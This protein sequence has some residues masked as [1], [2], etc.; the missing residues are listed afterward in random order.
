MFG[1]K[2]R[3]RTKKKRTIVQK[4][5]RF[6]M[7]TVLSLVLLVVA[8]AII[9]PAFFTD[10]IVNA[11]RE[12]VNTTIDAELYLDGDDVDLTLWS[13]FP[14]VTLEMNNFGV[15]G[16]GE[17]EGDTLVA[18]DKF[19]VEIDIWSL[20][21]DK[22]K[23]NGIYL[24]RPLIQ[25][26]VTK[27]GK[28]NWDIAL[29]DTT[30]VEEGEE[31]TEAG[32]PFEFKIDEW[33]ITK[34]R[35][36]YDDRQGDTYVEI[37]G[38]THSGTGDFE[39]DLTDLETHTIFE[40]FIVA[41]GGVTY[42]PRNYFNMNLI[43]AMSEG[44]TKFE[45]KDNRVQLNEFVTEFSG[46]IKMDTTTGNTEFTKFKIEA[47][48][49]AFKNI[50]SLVPGM[51]TE[52]F[53]ALKTSGTL[54][55]K[56][57]LDGTLEASGERIP[58][59]GFMLN[60]GDG[61]FQYPDL[62]SKVSKINVD[63]NVE[64]KDGILDNTVVNLKKFSMLMGSNPISATA[65]IEGLSNMNI[66]AT[67]NATLNLAELTSIYPIE[68]VKMKGIFTLNG[69]A[70]GQY[71]DQ[72]AIP[73]VTAKM[74]MDKGYV[75]ADGFDKAL[76]DLTFDSKFSLASMDMTSGKFDLNKFNMVM[77]ED[78]FSAEFH[79]DDLEAI[80]FN[81]N[82]QGIVDLDKIMAMFPIE[83]MEL[84]GKFIIE[85]ISTEGNL[86]AIE[87]ERYGDIPTSGSVAIDKFKYFDE[88]LVPG[89]ITIET[90][91]M[92]FT[93]KDIKL[94]DTRGMMSKSD[95]ST[96]GSI[97]NYMGYLFS[98]SD[99]VLKGNLTLVSKFFDL[100][101]WMYMYMGGEAPT[102]AQQEAALAEVTP[103]S[104][105]EPLEVYPLP[106]NI[107][108]RF[109]TVVNEV[110]YSTAP[111]TDVAG[112]VI[113]KDGAVYLNGMRFNMY[114][115]RFI[116]NGYYSTQ[117]P[118][119][120]EYSFDMKIDKM[121]FQDAYKAFA[122]AKKYLPQTKD[123]EGAFSSDFKIS[124]SLAKDY[125]PNFDD[126]NM[127]GL[128]NIH[129]AKAKDSKLMKA[130]QKAGV[131]GAEDDITIENTLVKANIK[132]GYVHFQPFDFK[133]GNIP[134]KVQGK[135]GLA[136]DIDYKMGTDVPAGALGS[137]LNSQLTKWGVPQTN[138]AD[139]IHLDFGVTGTHKNPKVKLL[140][141]GGKDIKDQV[142]DKI[143]DE[144]KDKIDQQIDNA[145]DKVKPKADKIRSDA[146]KEAADIRKKAKIE[147]DGVRATGQQTAKSLRD[148]GA[149]AAQKIRDEAESQAQQTE[150]S[151]KNPLEKKAKKIAADKI[152]Q[153]G[154]KKAKA[155]EEEFE[156]K[157]V[158]AEEKANNTAQGI[159]D[160]AEDA[161]SK[162]ESTADKQIQ[163]LMKE[164][165]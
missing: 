56:T 139:K 2:R 142:K 81:G 73:A 133:A 24:D 104:E 7:F 127:D 94:K 15:V 22:F 121:Q 149:K 164:C 108:F 122:V 23:I 115:G 35:L 143:K 160:K 4:I 89:P 119:K 78:E 34:G 148:E 27:D 43:V 20:F 100:D 28:A 19:K 12:E 76:E 32:S 150:N 147:A 105:E 165:N 112:T 29:P 95:F 8:A 36:L 117:N 67:T 5:L 50:L 58:A 9:I 66:D 153:E 38:L 65:L 59:L 6:L 13:N 97:D 82:F 87:E 75:K 62:P 123:I 130:V 42:F 154:E 11:V 159:E 103:T 60:V 47:K 111:L 79:V 107:N 152:R 118:A 44:Y 85:D 101:E 40:E 51:Y 88:T 96:Q 162:I 109:S 46:G 80:N 25:G 69:T 14:N 125:M 84:G 17:F 131:K 77:D 135:S 31:P 163:D 63:L 156:K 55:F 146:D 126:L 102:E 64:N 137:A 83:G 113:M 52:S 10:D 45:F 161:A 116:S 99:T 151:A 16:K 157:A 144:V 54:A 3:N 114:G 158:A 48:E 134:I 41:S 132:D 18:A 92:I 53:D 98:E 155:A 138:A 90:G 110:K 70:K 145:C 72:G 30:T 39:A 86:A 128:F 129:Q 49:T 91:K 140:T 74:G 68:G 1:K 21:G 61:S 136:G 57:E 141:A 33:S 93:P 120:P 106:R 26:L 37:N 124:G 71:N